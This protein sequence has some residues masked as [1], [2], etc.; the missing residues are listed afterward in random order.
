[1]QLA[2]HQRLA[3]HPARVTDHFPFQRFG[4][5]QPPHVGCYGGFSVFQRVSVSAF[6]ERRLLRGGAAGTGTTNNQQPIT[7]NQSISV[8]QHFSVSACQL[9]PPQ[10]PSSFPPSRNQQVSILQHLASATQE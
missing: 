6:E 5:S 2:H 7:N 10:Q 4:R 8:F 1:M 9:F 3:N